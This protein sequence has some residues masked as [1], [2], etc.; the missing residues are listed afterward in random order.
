MQPAFVSWNSQLYKIA[1]SWMFGDIGEKDFP[2]YF[3]LPFEN[4]DYFSME[5]YLAKLTKVRQYQTLVTGYYK[6]E[7]IGVLKSKLGSAAT[8]FATDLLIRRGVK[9]IVGIGYCGVIHPDWGSGEILVPEKVVRGFC[10]SKAYLPKPLAVGASTRLLAIAKEL[11]DL[12]PVARSANRPAGTLRFIGQSF[13]TDAILLEDSA[14]INRLYKKGIYAIDMEGGALLALGQRSGIDALVILV[15][16][17]N[18]LRC[19]RG[20]GEKVGD[21]YG[22]AIQWGL[23]IL[24]S[25]DKQAESDM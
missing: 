24:C 1:D 22:K 3:L 25:G 9:R 23:D 5:P 15:G 7:K 2:R 14:L 21:G 16:S 4:P 13:S 6:Q 20:D 10:V 8:A 17:D 11:S 18:P 12:H 19:E